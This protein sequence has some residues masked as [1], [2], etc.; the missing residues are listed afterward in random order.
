MKVQIKRMEYCKQDERCGNCI[1][2]E[3]VSLL[4]FGMCQRY[5]V[6]VRESEKRCEYFGRNN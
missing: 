4:R 1:F 3:R 5:K 6:A 2:F